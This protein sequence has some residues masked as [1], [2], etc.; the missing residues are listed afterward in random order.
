[1]LWFQIPVACRFLLL[2]AP[3]WHRGH[4]LKFQARKRAYYI[5]VIFITNKTCLAPNGG[6]TLK[7]N[8][9]VVHTQCSLFPR[10]AM[11]NLDCH[12]E[13]QLTTFKHKRPESRSLGQGT[14]E[15]LSEAEYFKLCGQ[16][17]PSPPAAS[18]VLL[19]AEVQQLLFLEP[20]P[21]VSR[22]PCSWV[23]SLLRLFPPLMVV[24][25]VPLLTTLTNLK[26]SR[27]K[28]VPAPKPV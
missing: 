26:L 16:K 13:P 21:S 9:C 22:S 3:P 18:S 19:P 8:I 7:H 25:R 28:T 1:M 11:A 27:R 17:R 5:A 10:I 24:T 4:C 14:C 20:S 15:S 23:G 12:S 2:R 6:K